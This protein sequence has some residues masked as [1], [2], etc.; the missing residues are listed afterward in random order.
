MNTIKSSR[1]ITASIEKVWNVISDVDND[2]KFWSNLNSI[3]NIRKNGNTIERDVRVGFRN[4]KGRQILTLVPN[5][6]IVIKLTEGPL[7]GTKVTELFPINNIKTKM[8]VSWNIE[9]MNA[10]FIARSFIEKQIRK[11]TE[12][13][14]D[15]IAK[16]VER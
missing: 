16:E 6:S 8:D 12:E 7:I 5:N 2:S 11:T 3:S 13:A 14:L 9:K 1:E 4:H 10:P 15:K